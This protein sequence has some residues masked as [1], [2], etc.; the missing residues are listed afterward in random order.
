M[1]VTIRPAARGNA[2]PLIGL[3]AQSGAGK[4]YSALLLAR[5]FVGAAGRIAMIETEQGRGEAFANPKEYPELTGPNPASNY[6]VIPIEGDFGPQ[7]YGEAITL[8]ERERV[9][10]LIIDSAS[11]E[12]E[13]IGGVLSR[14][15]DNQAAG[16][17]GPLVWQQPKMDH[18]RHFLLRVMQTPI[19]LVILCMRAKYPM[20]EV[21]KRGGGGKE[22]VRSDE[23]EPIQSENILFEM[24][25]HGWIEKDT[26]A[27]RPK[28]LTAKG[29]ASV[30][31]DGQPISIETG[32]AFAAWAREEAAPRRAD[33]PSAA[34]S[35]DG[36]IMLRTAKGERALP[37]A[38]LVEKL[39]QGVD[40]ILS[41]NG[42]SARLADLKQRNADAW[43]A[44]AK[45]A[46]EAGDQA[47][48][49]AVMEAFD[50]I[51]QAERRAKEAA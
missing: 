20:R 24:F 17:K 16:K 21:P 10:A 46:L 31:V 39:R 47:T 23:L 2:K 28:K 9:N 5:G 7:N 34:G 32:R 41:G 27:F 14:A 36:T 18:A 22:W 51:A 25:V 4:T 42:A 30:F 15:A 12:W 49:D 8:A 44:D 3:F 11:H 50:V 1:G 29:L 33:Q 6:D 48:Y 19:P 43:N 37:P 26:H 35:S 40:R 38:E 13:G 45:A